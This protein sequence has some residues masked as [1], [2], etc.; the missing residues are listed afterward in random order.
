[1]AYS[2]SVLPLISSMIFFTSSSTFSITDSG[3]G[4]GGGGSSLFSIAAPAREES[5]S[6]YGEDRSVHSQSPAVGAAQSQP[7][8]EH[9]SKGIDC[10]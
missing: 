3:G 10:G 7:R 9:H 6:R 2:F 8:L 4:G 1:M 5:R